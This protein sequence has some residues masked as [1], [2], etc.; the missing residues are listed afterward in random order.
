[1]HQDGNPVHTYGVDPDCQRCGVFGPLDDSLPCV[2]RDEDEIRTD[3]IDLM[4]FALT[5]IFVGGG[6]VAYLIAA[7]S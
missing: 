6:F 5:A 7:L 1:M 2:F 3:A 4:I